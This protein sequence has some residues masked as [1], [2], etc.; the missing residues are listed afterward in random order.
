[1]EQV[2]QRHA[3]NRVEPRIFAMVCK[4]DSPLVGRANAMYLLLE[5]ESAAVEVG[6]GWPETVAKIGLVR[7]GHAWSFGG[8]R[9]T[10]EEAA[11]TPAGPVAVVAGAESD[12]GAVGA[13]VVA[14]ES[15]VEMRW[16][17]EEVGVEAEI[18]V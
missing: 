12:F 16:S 11:A 3:W 18:E 8:Q 4:N 5:N 9:W 17:V 6:C 14:T 7:W 13:A 2:I 15:A 1:M 10:A